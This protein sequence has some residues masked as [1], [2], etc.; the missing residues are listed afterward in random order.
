MPLGIA[1][2]CVLWSP[3]WHILLLF[4]RTTTTYLQFKTCFT[5]HRPV[6]DYVCLCSWYLICY[7]YT[8]WCLNFKNIALSW[9]LKDCTKIYQSRYV[10]SKAYLTCFLNCC[11]YVLQHLLRSIERNLWKL[12]GYVLNFGSRVSIYTC[13]IILLPFCF[14]A[15]MYN[16]NDVNLAFYFN[17][18]LTLFCLE[19]L[20]CVA[21]V[22]CWVALIQTCWLGILQCSD[23]MSVCLDWSL[24]IFL[25]NIDR[26]LFFV[27][28]ILFIWEH[29]YVSQP[30]HHPLTHSQPSSL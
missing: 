6:S 10:C 17:F 12:L 13:F 30:L 1:T 19:K 11:I 3:L 7:S 18:V 2:I 29:L 8:I 22:V 20:Q 14:K 26:Q 25:S 23:L 15:L 4:D 24:P 5:F 21:F 9:H 28:Q 16:W 27:S